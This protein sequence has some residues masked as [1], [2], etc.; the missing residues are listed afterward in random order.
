MVTVVIIFTACWLPFNILMVSN[1][2]PTSLYS[3]HCANWKHLT[4]L[5]FSVYEWRGDYHFILFISL[6]LT[7]LYYVLPQVF[8][9][10]FVYCFCTFFLPFY[11]FLR[12]SFF[13]IYFFPHT[14]L[15][16]YFS[17]LISFAG[18]ISLSS[19]LHVSPSVSWSRHIAL[20]IYVWDLKFSSRWIWKMITWWY[21]IWAN[22]LLMK[23]KASTFT[24]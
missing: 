14:F 19:S 4:S 10:F 13:F 3:Y 21:W 23:Q 17:F 20:S 24:W 9:W 22:C 2:Q 6:C 16:I 18:L 7:Y 8:P 12:L 11:S 15:F 1:G 5:S